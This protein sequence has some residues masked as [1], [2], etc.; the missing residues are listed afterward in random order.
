VTDSRSQ[1]LEAVVR[2]ATLVP[3]DLVADWNR[4]TYDTGVMCYEGRELVLY[5]GGV[6]GVGDKVAGVLTCTDV[7]LS[8]KDGAWLEFSSTIAGLPKRIEL[9]QKPLRLVEGVWL[10]VPAQGRFNLSPTTGK[11]GISLQLKQTCSATY[12]GHSQF[13]RL[14]PLKDFSARSNHGN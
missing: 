4:C 9:N 3:L 7:D 5:H 12:M 1:Y 13:Y 6:N 2:A 10:F 14:H 11:W 8:S